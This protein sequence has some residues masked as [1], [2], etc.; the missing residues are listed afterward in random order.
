MQYMVIFTPMRWQVVKGSCLCGTVA[1]EVDL[2]ASRVYV[3]V[4]TGARFGH[5]HGVEGR[6]ASGSIKL[7]GGGEIVFDLRSFVTTW[8]DSK[9]TPA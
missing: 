2:G 7:G 3:K 6:L 4:G 8:L 5:G 1:F 9:T